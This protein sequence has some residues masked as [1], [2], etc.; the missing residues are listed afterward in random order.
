[1]QG[2][3][4]PVDFSKASK[5]GIKRAVDIAEKK[6]QS[7][8]LLNIIS[9]IKKKK[10]SPNKEEVLDST[11]NRLIENESKLT[12]LVQSIDFKD[13]PLHSK[14]I[15]GDFEKE[16]RKYITNNDIGLVVVGVNGA[17]TIGDLFCFGRDQK[18]IKLDCPVE[19]TESVAH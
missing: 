14:I 10:A 6:H 3:L 2:I 1:M 9:P 18:C 5:E 17:H 4:V 16:I 12:E 11:L 8:H 7:I 19:I 13:L 15:V